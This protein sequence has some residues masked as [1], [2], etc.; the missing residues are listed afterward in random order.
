MV[1]FNLDVAEE[2]GIATVE[3]I[4]RGGKKTSFEKIEIDIRNPNPPVTEVYAATLDPGK[5]YEKVFNSIGIPGTNNA[6]LEVSNIPPINLEARI[7]YLIHYPHG[8]LEQT[9][10]AAFPQLYLTEFMSL[11]DEKKREIDENIK[12]AIDKLKN[13]QLSNGGFAYWPGQPAT[14]DWSSSYAGHFLLEAKNRGYTVPPSLI[15]SWKDYQR[16]AANSWAKETYRFSDLAQAYRLYTLALA[17][18]PATGA[19]NRMREEG[20]YTVQAGWRLAA[21]YALAGQKDAGKNIV[22][23][24]STEIKEY[25]E[26]S[27]N[28]GTHHRDKAMILETLVL[29]GE[30][31]K[32]GS[33]LIE[34]SK[35]LSNTNFWM[36]TQETAYSLMAVGK[37]VGQSQRSDQINTDYSLNRAKN[38]QGKTELPFYSKALE[39]KSGKNELQ[40]ANKG[41]GVVFVRVVNTGVPLVGSETEASNQMGLEV[42][43]RDGSGNVIDPAFINQ[44]D[45]FTAEVTV[46]N[47]GYQ[48]HLKELALSQVFPSGWEIVNARMDETANLRSSAYDYQDIRD[49]RV[50]TYFDLRSGEKKTFRLKLI[51]TYAGRYYLPAVS[52]E[53]MYDRSVNARTKGKWVEVTSGLAQ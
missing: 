16:K 20:N 25:R 35:A 50:Y 34:V 51:A 1:E 8:C 32:A 22:K 31:E 24:L 3:I 19:M 11:P 47:L 5:S 44:G 41:N 18:S 49:D 39:I 17:G 29:L 4:A 14:H 52:C 46:A 37:F 13:F 21:A 9:L 27:Y 26:L 33:L 48:G 53:A 38:F 28:F 42:L 15:N 12:A 43:Y 10:S 6:T 36:S 30:S 2:T 40:V 7:R 45:H 23:N